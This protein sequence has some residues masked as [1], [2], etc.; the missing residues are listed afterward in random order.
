[1]SILLL[2]MPRELAFTGDWYLFD[3]EGDAATVL[4]KLPIE[5]LLSAEI[6]H[7]QGYQ[8][9]ITADGISVVAQQEVGWF[10]AEQTLLQLLDQF[11]GRL[12]ALTCCDWP[13]F[14]MRG[15][16]LDISRDRVHTMETLYHLIDILASWKINQLQL[17]TEHTFAYQNHRIVWE[18]ASPITAEEIQALDH[19][20]RERFIELVPNQNSFGHMRRWLI[21]E[22]Y[23]QLAECPYGCDTGREGWGHFD[24]P[25]TLCPIHSG[26]LALLDE[27][28]DELLPNFG[29]RL[30]NVG[31]DETVELGKGCSRAEVDAKGQG[32]VYLDFLLKIQ[33]KVEDR[34]HKMMFWADVIINYPDLVHELPHNM[35]AMDWGYEADHPFD[36]TLK[37][38]AEEH[39][40]FCVCVGTSS[41][42]SII[43]RS[44]N[45]FLNLRNG[46]KHGLQYGALG[47]FI[48]DW[49]DNG[50]WQFL[51][52]SYLWFG[53]GAALGWS[54][55]AN[56]EVDYQR[57]VSL[58]AFKDKAGYIGRFAYDL[59]NGDLLTGVRPHNNSFL[60]HVLQ[61]KLDELR[62]YFDQMGERDEAIRKLREADQAVQD[63]WA[64]WGLIELESADASLLEREFHWGAKML[65]H[66]CDRALW[67]LGAD[68]GE[69]LHEQYSWLRS[70]YEL[71]WHAR[72]RPGGF[73]DSVAH[74]DKMAQ[75]YENKQKTSQ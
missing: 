65:T 46:A 3:V 24:E 66:A 43:G 1:M 17:Y 74:L 49:G 5:R 52:A 34:G 26:S 29:S 47:Y 57:A 18:N 72:S 28:Y 13:D 69:S 6:D 22:P 42:N 11:S 19:Y 62:P 20:C 50:H 30:F 15:V 75:L 2:P 68:S 36:Q 8:L 63:V 54:A 21:H 60:F 27:L 55:D 53:Y 12:P 41:W 71:L 7:P 35:I 14:M 56:W 10:Y 40:P 16:T 64:R 32:R 59:G 48:T 9:V 67:M 73:V 45:A 51:P 58:W 61:N 4:K 44:E 37:L 25:F 38:L 70:E 31:C 33:Q 39:L 23:R